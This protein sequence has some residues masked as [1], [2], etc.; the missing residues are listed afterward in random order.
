MPL[1]MPPAPNR[2]D[3]DPEPP[4]P[5]GVICVDSGFFGWP[6]VMTLDGYDGGLVKR[7]SAS[8]GMTYWWGSVGGLVIWLLVLQQPHRPKARPRSVS[9]RRRMGRLR[10]EM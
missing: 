4:G 6:V 10:R 2:D 1:P 5:I 8:G 3:G 9:H 7:E